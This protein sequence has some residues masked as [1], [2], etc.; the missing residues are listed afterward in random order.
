MPALPLSIYVHLPWCVHK[1]P[2]CDFN[3]H[4]LTGALPEA[5]YLEQLCADMEHEAPRWASRAVQTIFLGGGTPSLFSADAIATL[6][7]R[8]RRTFA[9]ATDAEITLEANPGTVDAERFAGFRAAGVNRLSIGVQSFEDNALRRLGRIHDGDCA[10]RAIE[11]AQAAGFAHINVDLMHGLPEQTVAGAIH[12]L[13]IAMASGVGHVSWYQLT[14][15]PNTAFFRAPPPL[16]DEDRLDDIES[17]GYEQLLANGFSRYEVSA[18]CIGGATAQHNLNYWRFGDYIGLGAGAHGKHSVWHEDGLHIERYQKSRI[19]RDY[20][21]D[22]TR[23]NVRRV[24]AADLPFEFLLNALRLRDG[25]P[26]A[27]F[28]THTGLGI[29]TL[30]PALGQLRAEGLMDGDRLAAT[31]RG[32]RYLDSLLAAFILERPDSPAAP[33]HFSVNGRDIDG[34]AA[35]NEIR[36]VM[37]E[38]DAAALETGGRPLRWT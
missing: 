8:L 5:E 24:T 35:K 37:P 20:F 31:A 9:I 13:D 34:D 10:R 18:W 14:I 27:L 25:V 21:R 4:A 1:C 15:E 29:E 32:W 6:I 12:D 23:K 36:D 17:R 2:Y 26:E 3:S 22:C 19:P 38:G 16:P 28:A 11:F 7:S 30:Q 33:L